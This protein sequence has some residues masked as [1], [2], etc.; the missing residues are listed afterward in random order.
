MRLN[1]LRKVLRMLSGTRHNRAHNGPPHFQSPILL[2]ERLETRIVPATDNWMGGSGNWSVATDWSNGLPTAGEDITIP[3]SNITVTYTSLS[4]TLSINSLSLGSGATLAVASGSLTIA[5]SG[6]DMTASTLQGSVTLS[7]GSLSIA[8]GTSASFTN[9]V[10][11]NGGTLANATSLTIQ[12]LSLSSG[13][14][15]TTSSVSVDGLAWSGGVMTGGG[16]VTLPSGDSGTITNGPSKGLDT[17]LDIAGSMIDSST[18]QINLDLNN[19][20]AG[21]LDVVSGGSFNTT[22]GGGVLTTYSNSNNAVSIQGTFIDSSS[23]S[24]TATINAPFNNAG[25]VNI[26]SGK[27]SLVVT[28]SSSGSFNVASGATLGFDGGTHTFTSGSVISGLSGSGTGAVEIS[29][30]AVSFGSSANLATLPS[31]TISGGTATLS[32]GSGDATPSLTMSGGVLTGTDNLTVSTLSWSDGLMTGGGSTILSSGGSG[33]IANGGSKQLDR[34]LQIAGSIADSGSGLIALDQ[35]GDSAG[36]IDIVS[37]G[38]LNDSGGG[39][40]SYSNSNSGNEVLVQGT[41]TDS[42]TNPVSINVPFNNSGTVNVTAGKLSLQ[43]GGSDSGSF[44]VSASATLGFDGSP[45][46]TFSNG[47]SLTGAGTA[48]I[49]IG[50]V[51]FGSSVNLANMTAFSMSG[52][53][54]TFSTGA[55]VGMLGLTM[56][57]G[58]LTGS[59]TI[60]IG[61]LSWTG[62]TMTGAGMTILPQGDSGTLTTGSTK[63]L[64]RTLQIAGSVVDSGG[65]QISFDANNDS[66]GI[67]QVLSTGSFTNSGGGSLNVGN[68]NSGN[69][70]TNQGTFAGGSSFN[71]YVPFNSSGTVDLTAGTTSLH[72]GGTE[73]GAFSVSSSATLGFD[74]TPTTTFNSGSSLSGAGAAEI[75]TGAVDFTTGTNLAS[76]TS[77]TAG[78]GTATFS[79]SAAVMMSGLT[80]SGG[81]VTGSDTI[82]IGALSWTGGTMTGAGTTILPQG[83]SGTLTTGS[84]KGLDRTLQIAGSVVDSSGGQISFDA[85][86]DSAGILQILSTGSF[87]NSGGGSLNVGNSNSGNVFTNQGTFTG[88]SSFNIYVPFNSS[89][90]VDVTAGTTS[91]RGG[92][93][94]TGAFSVSSSATLGFDGTPTTTFNSGSS[95]T[96]AA[97]PKSAPVL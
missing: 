82:T 8:S 65:G 4:G 66:A 26:S 15:T 11:L 21:I 63:G 6:S 70:F 43:A 22:A 53:T 9:L 72:G 33:T 52:G 38:S 51:S 58:L 96:G 49:S 35:A 85:N 90:T 13:T 45:T 12:N 14:L 69:V 75:S 78:G 59:D 34:T 60:T 2:L 50:A 57:G 7:G 20:S 64:D 23:A 31:F 3:N 80:I 89:G 55:A 18:N 56:S 28:D 24:T 76:M 41:F 97:L 87:T 62:G 94:E 92:G 10:T 16:T 61:A 37:G 48:E 88:G 36:V 81:T 1:I 77:F 42:G 17:T 79:T 29:A 39:A 67:L 30:G 93:T 40:I 86:N 68:S 73:T 47:S 71:I 44:S 19:D 25:T 27:L 5:E 95:L 83:D 74:G 84:T 32:T 91:L 46:T 54:A